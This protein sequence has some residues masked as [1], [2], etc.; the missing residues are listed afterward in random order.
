MYNSIHEQCTVK[1]IELVFHWRNVVV[2]L[3]SHV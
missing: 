3:L 2:Q 1:F